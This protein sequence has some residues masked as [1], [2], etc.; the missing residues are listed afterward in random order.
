MEPLQYFQKIHSATHKQYET[1]RAFF[2]EN[3]TA[4]DVAEKFGYSPATIYSL[5]KDF[6]RRL[7]TESPESLFFKQPK[8]GRA[9]RRDRDKLT[10][11]VIA[12]R[13]KNFSVPDIKAIL[14]AQGMTVSEGTI[15]QILR[16]DGFA[17]LPR[18]DK[19]IRAQVELPKLEARK[20]ILREGY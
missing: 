4:E 9:F 8:K 16:Q 14:D 5:V 19:Q 6:R 7:K 13:K 20:S 18:R 2:P 1:L 17:R 12:L 15:L 3:M 11:L 10:T